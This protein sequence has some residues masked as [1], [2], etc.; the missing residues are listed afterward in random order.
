MVEIHDGHEEGGSYG[1]TWIRN[2]DRKRQMKRPLQ[3]THDKEEARL[4]EA[5]GK[6]PRK[7]F[8]RTQDGFYLGGMRN[9]AKAVARMHGT[10]EIGQKMRMAWEEFYE[11]RKTELRDFGQAYGTNEAAFDPAM[12]REWQDTLKRVL[13][14]E[15]REGITVR[16]NFEFK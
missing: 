3:S 5:R 14:C 11:A 6:M 13:R 1:T 16:E 10:Q 9:P 12:V 7:E 2:V 8:R 15:A 4:P